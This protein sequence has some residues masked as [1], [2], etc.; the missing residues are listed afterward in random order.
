[1]NIR[2]SGNTLVVELAIRLG[3]LVDASESLIR[4][5]F[6]TPGATES[7]WHRFVRRDIRT[8]YFVYPYS[9]ICH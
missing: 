4:F 3:C 9:S 8:M 1:M 7:T 5:S 2:K 6:T